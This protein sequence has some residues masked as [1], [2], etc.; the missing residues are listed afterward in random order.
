MTLPIVPGPFHFLATLGQA[1]GE[2]LKAKHADEQ[3]KYDD[4][5][6]GSILWAEM[7]RSGVIPHES[8]NTPEV[9]KMFKTAKLPLPSTTP[10]VDELK[11]NILRR[12]MGTQGK[13]PGSNLDTTITPNLPGVG[14]SPIRINTGP[15]AV[16]D[17]ERIVAGLPTRPQMAASQLAGTT[18][19]A[20]LPGAGTTALAGQQQ[21]Q[22]KTFNDIADRM[23]E[24]AYIQGGKKLPTVQDVARYAASDPRAMLFGAN[25]T[26]AHY[27]AAVER[28]RAKLATED[29]NRLAAA[30]RAAAA[31]NQNDDQVKL[32]AQINSAIAEDNDTVQSFFK[33]PLSTFKLTQAEQNN[34]AYVNDPEV[35]NYRVAQKRLDINRRALS[36]IAAGK[37]VSPE[38]RALL[39]GETTPSIAA[40]QQAWDNAL[41]AAAKGK[42][43]AGVPKL[44]GESPRAYIIRVYGARP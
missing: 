43:K 37:A 27:G 39:G 8:A 13:T 19:E 30:A 38:A 17:E 14:P 21:E 16:S 10:S 5:V 26:E 2:A 20:Q 23:A 33:S 28:L 11:S 29:T 15:N 31:A 36:D 35:K 24:T 22:D 9:I 7:V 40:R 34:P 4:A 25:I 44:P 1:G 12:F 18:A 41:S 6:K 42:T 32:M 3:Q